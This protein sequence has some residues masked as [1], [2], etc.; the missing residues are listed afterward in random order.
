MNKGELRYIFPALHMEATGRSGK[1]NLNSI[2][3]IKAGR[4]GTQKMLDYLPPDKYKNIL[5]LGG[6]WKEANV[7]QGMGYNCTHAVVSIDIFKELSEDGFNVIKTDICDMNMINNES[8]DA[9]VSVQTLEH[10]YYPWKVILETYRVLKDGGRGMYNIPV[11]RAEEKDK[12]I[13]IRDMASL[14]HV[15]ILEPYQ[16]KAMLRTAGFKIIWHDIHL[17]QQ[18]I[19][20]DKLS[21]KELKEY[22]KEYPLSQYYNIKAHDFLKGYCEI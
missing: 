14:Q 21:L 10:V 20:F 5:N 15:S 12:D 6:T 17:D 7:Y 19:Y 11:W 1:G 13:P 2:L 22:P 18:T 9:I 4:I 8:F 3:E 16:Y